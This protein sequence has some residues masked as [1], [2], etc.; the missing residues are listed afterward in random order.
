MYILNIKALKNDISQAK[1]TDRYILPYV[2]GY[3]I[4]V[5]LASALSIEY[6]AWDHVA[7]VMIVLI[8]GPAVY[9]LYRSNSNNPEGSFLS[10]WILMSWVCSFRFTIFFMVPL[11]II[12]II[13]GVSFGGDIRYGTSMDG[14]M[15]SVL[16][17]ILLVVYTAKHIKSIGRSTA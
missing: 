15:V 2:I 14:S 17:Y 7:N 3:S 10:N 5:S 1:V 11:Y 16:F 8:T 6:N 4:L 12:M 9:Y 13:A